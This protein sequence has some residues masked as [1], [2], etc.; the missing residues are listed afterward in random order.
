MLQKS[1][2]DDIPRRIDR[3]PDCRYILSHEYWIERLQ[4][5]GNRAHE[6]RVRLFDDSVFDHSFFNFIAV[7]F[8]TIDRVLTTVSTKK[9]KVTKTT[10]IGPNKI[11]V[12]KLI[13]LTKTSIIHPLPAKA[14]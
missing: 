7:S 5:P 8:A 10:M 1:L 14:P 12:T 2:V 3:A 6:F 13:M 9:P 4:D 11:N